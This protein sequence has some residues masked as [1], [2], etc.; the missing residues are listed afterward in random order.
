MTVMKIQQITGLILSIAVTVLLVGCGNQTLNS[1]PSNAVSAS[2]AQALMGGRYAEAAALMDVADF[3]AWQ[4][5][6]DEL[7]TIHRGFDGYQHAQV[8][9]Q[10]KVIDRFTWVWNDGMRHC[11]D[12]ELTADDRIR[13]L[14]PTYVPCPAP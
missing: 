6:T 12:V 11:L 3:E 5:A 1:L 8:I 9:E 2:W 14:S 4:R 7:R 10:N 13:P